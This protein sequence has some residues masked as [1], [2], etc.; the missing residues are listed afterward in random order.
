MKLGFA[1]LGL[2]GRPMASNIVQAGFPL[3]AYS[4]SAGPREALERLGART[5][6]E[7]AELFDACDTVILMLADDCSTDAVLG[8]GTAGFGR[9]VRGKLIVNMGTH[10]PA[11]SKA[12]ETDL[13][14]AGARFVEAPVSGSRGPA[15]AGEL[16]AML[17]GDPNGIEQLRPLLTHLCRETIAT[18][19]VPSAM[20]CKISVNLYLIASVAALAEGMA[21]AKKLGL[22][23]DVFARVIGQ[24][25]LGSDVARAKLHKMIIRDFAP[26]ASIR[27][28][29]KNACLVADTAA[30]A[31]LDAQALG[32]ARRLFEG[33][34]QGGGSELDMAG[35]ITAWDGEGKSDE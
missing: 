24:G 23:P 20:A 33:V 17:A 2:M 7:A 3:A 28:V 6:G 25:P 35:V 32:S 15:E 1:G 31:K 18:G 10:A 5:F 8:R 30:T 27:D 12:L 19:P 11:W 9:Q 26:E 14:A 21:L 13:V 34:L 22:D 4:R 16:V 29:C